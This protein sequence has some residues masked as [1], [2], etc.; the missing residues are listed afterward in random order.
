MLASASL[1][2]PVA[3]PNP[4]RLRRWLASPAALGPGGI[5]WSWES[6]QHPG[7]DYPEAAGLWLQAMAASDPGPAADVARRLQPH[8]ATGRVGRDARGYAFDLGVALAGL[9]AARDAGI[10]VDSPA[11]TRGRASLLEAIAARRSTDGHHA[12]PPRW[13]TWWGPH[14]L[15]LAFVL[16]ALQ[17]PTFLDQLFDDAIPRLDGGRFVTGPEAGGTYVHAHC[18]ASEGLWCVTHRSARPATRR[19]AARSLEAATGWLADIQGHDGSL[20][21]W[22]DGHAA[23][24]PGRSDATAQAVRL[25]HLQGRERHRTAI[26]RALRFLATCVDDA[27]GVRY[28]TDCRDRT[29]W[30]AVFTLQAA[31]LTQGNPPPPGRGLW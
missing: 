1:E 3:T 27:G 29:T 17:A 16:D 30:S 10:A 26:A 15:K 12:T 24:G 8:V 2:A 5:V 20:P 9:L 21:A 31:G 14:L 18:Y 22:H 7:F 6:D 19:E 11:I 13:S 4:A 28:D 23:R 25:W